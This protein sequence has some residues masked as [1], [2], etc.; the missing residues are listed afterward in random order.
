MTEPT[1][2]PT[3]DPRGSIEVEPAEIVDTTD[4]CPD[5]VTN[6][7]D[8]QYHATELPPRWPSLPYFPPISAVPRDSAVEA[9][10]VAR[11]LLGTVV[12][13][14]DAV[15]PVL[16]AGVIDTA[17]PVE[18]TAELRRRVAMVSDVLI[19]RALSPAGVIAA[20]HAARLAERVA[21]LTL[22]ATP[23]VLVFR[24]RDVFGSAAG[25]VQMMGVPSDVAWNS[26]V[27]FAISRGDVSSRAL[28][29]ALDRD[30]LTDAER[31]QRAL[32]SRL[33]DAGSGRAEEMAPV[34]GLS[35]ERVLELAARY[36]LPL[37]ADPEPIQAVDTVALIEDIISDTAAAGR[38]SQRV[39]PAEITRMSPA[40]CA[41]WSRELWMSAKYILQLRA[42][43]DAR[44]TGK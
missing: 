36:D 20:Q 25:T 43:L 44:A 22:R 6:P 7:D 37:P 10:R 27:E 17:H 11:D 23:P 42:R 19:R 24:P 32:M 28:L 39:D 5:C 41:D 13:Y 34:L 33:V 40:Q 4:V 30:D 31:E 18:D 9:E 3:P 14:R 26:A 8:C 12:A 15:L 38:D 16:A 2:E 1:T 29:A 21:G 35:A